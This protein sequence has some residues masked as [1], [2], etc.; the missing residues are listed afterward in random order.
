MQPGGQHDDPTNEHGKTNIADCGQRE[1]RLGSAQDHNQGADDGRSP[2][3]R[4]VAG[5]DD[6]GDGYAREYCAAGGRHRDEGPCACAS[7]VSAT[8]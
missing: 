3:C 2:D 4:H 7:G 6:A 5:Q 8:D 1:E